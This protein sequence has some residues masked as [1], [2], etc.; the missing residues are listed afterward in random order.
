MSVAY[1]ICAAGRGRAF[2]CVGPVQKRTVFGSQFL[3]ECNY[4]DIG[5]I[6]SARA[7]VQPSCV[8]FKAILA[9]RAHSSVPRF[10]GLAVNS[11]QFFKTLVWFGR[12]KPRIPLSGWERPTPRSLL[13]SSRTRPAKA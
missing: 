1:E 2:S 12:S 10:A 5:N 8:E 13:R 9:P 11:H 6:G 4:C 7:L 3:K